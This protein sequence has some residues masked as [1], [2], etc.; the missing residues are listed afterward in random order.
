MISEI[1]IF[2]SY[3]KIHDQKVFNE[4]TSLSCSAK[5]FRI[6]SGFIQNV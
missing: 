4:K 1:H 3:P 6:F 5:M 2:R